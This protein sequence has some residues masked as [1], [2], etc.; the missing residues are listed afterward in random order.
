MT[1][2]HDAIAARAIDA[3]GVDVII[4]S[5][6]DGETDYRTGVVNRDRSTATVRGNIGR[7]RTGSSLDGNGIVEDLSVLVRA[8]DVGGVLAMDEN[9]ELR[10]VGQ[11]PDGSWRSIVAVDKRCSGTMLE[12]RTRRKV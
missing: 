9:D 1:I 6:T 7:S 8:S 10:I 12:L 2:D 4:R 5:C 3:F 11:D